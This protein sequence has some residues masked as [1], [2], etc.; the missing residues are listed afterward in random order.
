M[1][2]LIWRWSTA[3]QMTSLLM[4]AVFF[5]ALTRSVR[6]AELRW[7]IAAWIIN[8]AALG[9]AVSFWLFQ[10]QQAWVLT[11]LRGLYMGTKAAYVLFL[12]QG[13][14]TLKRPGSRLLPMP[15]AL[16]ALVVY[17]VAGALLVEGIALLGVVQQ[18]VV[19]L[20]FAVGV[21]VTARRP[22]EGGIMW[23][24]T[25]F[26]I[27][28][29]LGFVES[30]SYAVELFPKETFSATFYSRAAT[31]SAAHSSFDSGAEWLVALGCVLALSERTQRELRKYNQDLLTA[32]ESLRQIADHDSL[33]AL[34]NRR[35]LPAV[36]RAVQPQGATLL[37]FDLDDFKAINDLHGHHIGDECLKRFADGLR[38]C[39]R[40]DDALIRYAGDEFLV[41]A[42]GLDA[43]SIKSRLER[44]RTRLY[45]SSQGRR[46]EIGFSVGVAELPAGGHPDAAL[47]AADDAMYRA[48]AVRRADPHREPSP[49]STGLSLPRPKIGSAIKPKS[50]AATTARRTLGRTP[51]QH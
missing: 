45:L 41:V 3:V 38:E 9:I 6:L 25:G 14:W 27:R 34:A 13:A 21:V 1:D 24:I 2:L 28:S 23:L 29:V 43:G 10:P 15:V 7:W 18:A 30:A 11:L 31:F 32:Q 8:L 22:I 37:F 44:L 4:I 26:A 16:T 49:R 35:T 46:P 50:E 5:T 39:F 36:F 17:T 42:S 47:K 33:T 51:R 19:G 20:L 12:I 48:K 40:P